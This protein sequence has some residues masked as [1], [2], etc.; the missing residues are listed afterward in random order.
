[1]KA[2]ARLNT[3]LLAGALLAVAAVGS[4]SSAA[5]QGM[6]QEQAAAVPGGSSGV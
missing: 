1:M 4:P 6:T 5:A 3:I 2:G